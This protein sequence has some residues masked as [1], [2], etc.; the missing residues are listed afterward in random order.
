M[1][2]SMSVPN[3][4]ELRIHNGDLA[5]LRG[6]PDSTEKEAA[7]EE[8]PLTHERAVA[9]IIKAIRGIRPSFSEHKL[10]GET[11]LASDLGFES[12]TT[13][14]LLLEVQGV[15]DVDLDVGVSV[16]SAEMT[17]AHLAD[18]V[19]TLEHCGTDWFR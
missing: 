14:E 19:V 7:G 6:L 2:P 17:I 1:T 9:E 11:N 5:Y 8:E 10:N 12:A 18:L 4:G 13:V 15:L 3:D 16:M